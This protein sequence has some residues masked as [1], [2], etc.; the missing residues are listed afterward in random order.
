MKNLTNLV[1]AITGG[2][3]GIGL[4]TA[5]LFAR[6]G[7]KLALLAR[8]P[9]KLEKAQT[10]LAAIGATAL[11]LPVDVSDESA[12][13]AA[14]ARIAESLG[15]V[16]ILVNNAGTGFATDLSTCS[17]ADY[18]RI[19][20]TNVTGVF[21]CSKAVLSSM[22]ERKSGHIINVSSIVGKVSNPNAPLYCA[23]KH[24]LNGYNSGLQQQ[25]AEDKIRISL[26]SPS[27][28]DTAYWDGRQVDRSKFLSPGEVAS[29]IHFVASQPEGVLIKDVDLSAFAR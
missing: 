13:A 29:V 7:S 10:E 4:E 14:F 18:R 11:A 9:E 20:E 27:A 25:V 21:L 8:S 23:S 12:V 15:P 22:K 5:K 24:A 16:D 3:S 19:F 26:V 28:V 17:L 6:S 2:S 1:V